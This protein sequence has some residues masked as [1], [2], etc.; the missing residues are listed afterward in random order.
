[1][2]T[3]QSLRAQYRAYWKSLGG[4]LPDRAERSQS[5]GRQLEELLGEHQGRCLGAYMALPDEPELTPLLERLAQRGYD[6]CLP[7]VEGAEMH[8]FRWD[9]RQQLAPSGA[10][11]I[12]EPGGDAPRVAPES[13]DLV[14]VPAI[15]FDT[16]HY[17]LGR[18]R[19]YYDKYLPQTRAFAV[20]VS[21]GLWQLQ[22]LPRDSWDRPM[23]LVL[24]P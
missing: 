11:G 1:M 21:L 15:A 7:R 12:R 9:T 5:I 14:I 19:G 13:L 10:F 4:V 24:T 2:Q 23:D 3:K 17:R 8:F 20:G 22:E 16:R 18:G 6:I